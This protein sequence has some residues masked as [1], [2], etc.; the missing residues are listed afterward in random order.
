MEPLLHYYSTSLDTRS[1]NLSAA[2]QYLRIHTEACV[3]CKLQHSTFPRK[4]VQVH[5]MVLTECVSF[6]KWVPNAKT[7]N[8]STNMPGVV[9]A[10][11]IQDLKTN[12]CWYIII[13]EIIGQGNFLFHLKYITDLQ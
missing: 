1:I 8:V 7:A 6:A 10:T 2:L 12:C 11:V 4:R 13:V 5:K 9:N 3:R